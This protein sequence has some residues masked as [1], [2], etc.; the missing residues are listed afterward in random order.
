MATDGRLDAPAQSLTSPIFVDRQQRYSVPNL[1]AQ[2]VIRPKTRKPAS[3]SFVVPGARTALGSRASAKLSSVKGGKVDK[4]V[5]MS[6]RPSKAASIHAA[7]MELD[8]SLFFGGPSGPLRRATDGDTRRKGETLS[9]LLETSFFPDQAAVRDSNIAPVNTAVQ[10]PPPISCPNN[11]LPDTPTSIV[12]TPTE[13]YH[14]TPPRPSRPIVRKERLKAKKR[15][16][17]AQVS[18]TSAKANST[19][20]LARNEEISPTRLSAIPE[21]ST[22]SE[23]TPLPSGAT[24]PVA[25]EIHLRGGSVLTLSPPELT[26]WKQSLYVQGPIKLP[27]PVVVPRKDS[28]ASLE[29]FQDAIDQVYQEAL[30]ISRRRSDDAVVDEVCDFFDDF[31]FDEVR[32]ER[33]SLLQQAAGLDD[34]GRDPD[35]DMASDIERFS[36]P[37][38]EPTSPVEKVVAKEILETMSHPALSAQPHIPPVENEE[39]LR[40]KGIARLSHGVHQPPAVHSGRKDSLTISRVEPTV[41]PLLPLPEEGI[42]GAVVEG[43]TLMADP[44]VDRGFDVEEDVQELDKSSTWVAP[45]AIPRRHGMTRTPQRSGKKVRSDIVL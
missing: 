12:P 11:D 20:P 14:G 25:T 17:L 13:M 10:F 22:T 32:F 21:L 40:A 37:P 28:V 30:N 6:K 45:A 15:S 44:V 23:N 36:T 2:G 27:K 29:P 4:T 35:Q 9:Q 26:A 5:T 38:A 3:V 42:L 19:S 18:T 41:L 24:S 34:E 7:L 33:Y 43:D 8:E 39:T 1:D 31:G 16:P